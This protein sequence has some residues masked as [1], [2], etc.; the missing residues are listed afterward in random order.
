M[1]KSEAL[2]ILQNNEERKTA[3]RYVMIKMIAIEAI[4]KQI[5]KKPTK[6]EEV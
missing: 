2:N 5:P 1:R 4:E 3:G 6:D